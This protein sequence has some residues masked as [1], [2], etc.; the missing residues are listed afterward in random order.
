MRTGFEALRV[1][2]ALYLVPLMFAYSNLISGD[3]TAMVFDAT[4][5]MLWLAMFPLATEGYYFGRMG[6]G[7]RVAATAA[8]AAFFVST[9]SL[10]VAPTLAWLG[11]GL[12][13][14]VGLTLYQTRRRAR[15]AA[16]SAETPG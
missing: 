7:G 15:R 8:G 11:T 6:I 12:A 5:G 10:E 1:A 4:A 14:M 16:L 9:F 3:W 13:I 2:K